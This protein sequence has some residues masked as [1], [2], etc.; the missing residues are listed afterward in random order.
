METNKRMKRHLQNGR[1]IEHA[2]HEGPW[3]LLPLRN[4]D[5]HSMLR[6]QVQVPG[7]STRYQA[8]LML[9]GLGAAK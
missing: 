6:E 2:G 5:R 3:S 7:T 8:K 4:Y 9:G 1:D